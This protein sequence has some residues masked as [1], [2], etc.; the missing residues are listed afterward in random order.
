MNELR[1]YMHQYPIDVRSP[2]ASEKLDSMARSYSDPVVILSPKEIED[3]VNDFHDLEIKCDSIFNYFLQKGWRRV[4]YH[5]KNLL[6]SIIPQIG[7]GDYLDKVVDKL[8]D[9][10][11]KK[12]DIFCYRRHNG[13]MDAYYGLEDLRASDDSENV[14]QFFYKVDVR[15]SSVPRTPYLIIHIEKEFEGSKEFDSFTVD[16]S[17][18][19]PFDS[20][21]K[22][23]LK[24]K[25]EQD[26][27]RIS[28]EIEK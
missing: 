17:R 14:I 26:F 13:C 1:N 27:K 5:G 9:K 22:K 12:N 11:I 24:E 18:E 2:L 23:T 21:I 6:L 10:Y 28:K 16:I 8:Q 3:A 15:V 4:E 19:K 20:Y 25:I 7:I